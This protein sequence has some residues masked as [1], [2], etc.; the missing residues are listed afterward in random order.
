LRIETVFDNWFQSKT[1]NG[2]SPMTRTFTFLAVLAAAV[3]ASAATYAGIPAA[4]VSETRIVARD[5]VWS[6]G[7][8]ACQGNTESSRPQVLCQSLARKAG[9]LSRFAVDGRAFADAELAKCNAAARGGS[10]PALA[11]AN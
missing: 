6:C 5:I 1:Q 8:S 4:P 3:P 2:K 7:A 10:Q 11:A 9:T